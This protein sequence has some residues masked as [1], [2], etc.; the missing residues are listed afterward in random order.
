MGLG[1]VVDHAARGTG[2]GDRCGT[3][4]TLA[5]VQVTGLYERELI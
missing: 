2:R 3:V 1:T 4:D 5:A